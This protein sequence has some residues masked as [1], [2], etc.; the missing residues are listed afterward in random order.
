MDNLRVPIIA[1]YL[2]IATEVEL[3]KSSA[4]QCYLDVFDIPFSAT[5]PNCGMLVKER[6]TNKRADA[7]KNLEPQDASKI[8]VY[9]DESDDSKDV[10]PELTNYH[11]G[12]KS[13]ASQWRGISP[14]EWF[15][16]RGYDFAAP[17]SFS[18]VWEA[19]KSVKGRTMLSFH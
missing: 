12:F 17:H 10:L 8:R 7:L 5:D 1:Y 6:H 4:S 13:I 11:T 18:D 2:G 14:D 15:V 9:V 19:K 16:L 3:G